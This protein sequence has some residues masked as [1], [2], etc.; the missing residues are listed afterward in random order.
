[1]VVTEWWGVALGGAL[2]STLRFAVG[3]ALVGLGP[4][5]PWGTLA[6]NAVGSALGGLVWGLLATSWLP[7]GARAPL[8]VGFLGGLTTFS[9]L[10][11]EV[12]TL[13]E[14][15]SWGAA[16]SHLVANLGLGLL[17]A[18]AGLRLGLALGASAGKLG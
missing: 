14:R 16:L 6:V 11:V 10:S 15:G 3:R 12:V 1:V 2:G 18:W 13:A 8:A 17:A 5:L 7:P 4:D 9:A